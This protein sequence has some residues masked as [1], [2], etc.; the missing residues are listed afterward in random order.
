[1]NELS[2]INYSIFTNIYQNNRISYKSYENI[3]KK[4]KYLVGPASEYLTLNLV[5]K[6]K[7]EYN[8]NLDVPNEFLK[9]NKKTNN[10]EKKKY[11]TI[12]FNERKNKI[13]NNFK[14]WISNF[15]LTNFCKYLI[16][17]KIKIIILST[18][19]LYSIKRIIKYYNINVIDIFSSKDFNKFKTKGKIINKIVETYKNEKDF[20]FID[21]SDHHLKTVNNKKVKV[22]FADWGYQKNS[23][24]NKFD[25]KKI[26]EN[27]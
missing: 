6:K 9:I 24:F 14:S 17:K 22:Y 15:K 10:F 1:M 11:E 21:D 27:I 25:L 18:K 3:F 13:K 7:Y 12:F 26:N 23:I 2:L 16:Q 5:I 4:Y 19:D 8:K 20:I